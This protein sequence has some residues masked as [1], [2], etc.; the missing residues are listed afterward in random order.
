MN[1]FETKEL[2]K[3]S[4]TFVRENYSIDP[5][6]DGTKIY[7]QSS[8][9]GAYV[10]ALAQGLSPRDEAMFRQLAKNLREYVLQEV[11]V[12]PNYT[13]YNQL[14]LPLLRI[15][16]PRLV[17]RE[18][19]TVDPIDKPFTIKYFIKAVAKTS[20]GT[21][22]LP[23]YS[24]RVSS[25]PIIPFTSPIPVTGGSG[26][27]NLV[28]LAGL[29][30][31][32]VQR[33]VIIVS[34]TDG[35]DTV[36]VNVVPDNLSGAATFSV[37]Y[38]TSGNTDDLIVN[39]NFA[40]GDV[41]IISRDGFT[42]GVYFTGSIAMESN[43]NMSEVELKLEPYQ[44]SALTRKLNVKWSIEFEQ[45]VKALFDL[46][47]QAQMLNILGAQ[48]ATDI[49][50]EILNDLIAA[51]NLSG[52]IQASFPKTPP[53][54]FAFGPKQ[55]YENVVVPIDAISGKIYDK[56]AIAPAN[57]IICNPLDAAIFQA[58]GE[59]SKTGDLTGGEYVGTTPYKVGEL[60]NQY[61]FLIT[62]L[63]PQGTALVILNPVE[64]TAAVYAYMPYI[65]VTIYPWPMTNV[66]SVTYMTRYA[67]R[68]FRPFGIGR[69]NITQS[70]QIVLP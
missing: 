62:Q 65:P 22:E 59:Y 10:D 45:D 51:T 33:D 50:K 54:G 31:G 43:E 5:I 38:P 28:A 52:G 40:S 6:K 35:T 23:D 70:G 41:S 60:G 55:W 13:A 25:G 32:S 12:T 49:D 2:L 66:P 17:A 15:F 61:K 29:T 34:V 69:L 57:T 24:G 8:A 68:V 14:L 53:S 20:S 56:T 3:E 48:I 46:D 67:K 18:A 21:R 44:I 63:M 16:F 9:Y 64:P 42:T 39:I 7:K 26:S 47:A 1:L 30:S 36:T 4:Y 27:G 37:T 19:I 11:N 58:T